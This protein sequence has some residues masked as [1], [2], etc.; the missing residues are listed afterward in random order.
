MTGTIIHSEYKITTDI[1]Y[2]I[3]LFYFLKIY[4][5]DRQRMP[6]AYLIRMGVAFPTK[7]TYVSPHRIKLQY[8]I[9]D[10]QIGVIF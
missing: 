4:V 10:F 9:K 8:W 1:D 6:G 3:E 7:T 5:K 2:L